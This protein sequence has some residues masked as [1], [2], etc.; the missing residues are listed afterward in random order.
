M[1]FAPDAVD[2]AGLCRMMIGVS[3]VGF[4]VTSKG[5]VRMTAILS[6]P[7]VS[8]DPSCSEEGSWIPSQAC[9]LCAAGRS[10]SLLLC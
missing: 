8:G 5:G 10:Q 3:S 9:A 7:E 2:G 6:S 4:G 1:R